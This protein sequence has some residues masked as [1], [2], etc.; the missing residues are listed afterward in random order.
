MVRKQ[1]AGGKVE[2]GPQRRCAGNRDTRLP[3]DDRDSQHR[4]GMANQEVFRTSRQ[5]LS[6][7]NCRPHT[8]WRFPPD[9]SILR[10]Q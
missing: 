3:H 5:T 7:C 2:V 1:V 8:R 9:D 4:E 10:L 6:L